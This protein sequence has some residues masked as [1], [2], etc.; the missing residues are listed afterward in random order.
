MLMINGKE[1]AYPIDRWNTEI[2][3][4]EVPK[5]GEPLFIRFVKRLQEGDL[6]LGMGGMVTLQVTAL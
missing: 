3:V 4:P 5:N 2:Q 6:Q 1:Y